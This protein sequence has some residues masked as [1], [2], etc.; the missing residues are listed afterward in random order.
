ML[1]SKCSF[2]SDVN[3]ALRRMW[4]VNTVSPLSFRS[5]STNTEALQI[6]VATYEI[7][8]ISYCVQDGSKPNVQF[9]DIRSVT[10]SVPEEGAGQNTFVFIYI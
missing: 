7:G 1:W 9:R 2:A 4:E 10:L 3:V 5:G 6:R 8:L